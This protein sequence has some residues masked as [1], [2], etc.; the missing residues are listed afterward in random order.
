MSSPVNHVGNEY[1][2]HF[3]LSP[4][5]DTAALILSQHELTGWVSRQYSLHVLLTSAHNNI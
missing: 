5:Q 2:Y 4:Q 3:M 1:V